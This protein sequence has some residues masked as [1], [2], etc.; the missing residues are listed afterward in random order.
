[1][2]LECK[3]RFELITVYLS[4]RALVASDI[5]TLFDVT[6]LGNCAGIFWH[7]IVCMYCN[8]RRDIGLIL[9]FKQFVYIYYVY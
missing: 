8:S 3:Y 2:L 1:M 7:L 6:V 5:Y 4:C 9:V